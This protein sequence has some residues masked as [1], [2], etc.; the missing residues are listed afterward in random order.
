MLATQHG[1]TTAEAIHDVVELFLGKFDA[2]YGMQMSTPKWHWMLHFH[3]HVRQFGWLASCW[4]LERKHKTPK[5]Y[6]SDI[7]NTNSY[8]RSVLREVTCEH[9]V[10]LSDPATFD[11]TRVGLIHAQAAPQRVISDLLDELGMSRDS[12]CDCKLANRSHASETV[13]CTVGDVVFFE[14]DDG[15]A[16]VGELWANI[17]LEGFLLTIVSVWAM[18]RQAH[19]VLHC[20]VTENPKLVF[21]ECIKYTS[22]WAMETRTDAVVLMPRQYC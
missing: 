20:R 19:G 9:M 4:P 5:A 3:D 16:Q 7:R 22:I 6:G 11:F 2:A 14:D 13:W 17:S 8:E 15:Q 10:H 21:A 12:V 18:Q 1:L